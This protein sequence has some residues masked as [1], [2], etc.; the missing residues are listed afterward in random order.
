[1]SS[2]CSSKAAKA[3]FL[4]ICA[5]PTRSQPVSARA[6]LI[7][8]RELQNARGASRVCLC[9]V[10]FAMTLSTHLAF[11]GSPS[12]S[13]SPSPSRRVRPNHDFRH[14]PPHFSC[15][16]L[17]RPRQELVWHQR[18]RDSDR[19]QAEAGT[20][21]QGV[22]AGRQA[23]HGYHGEGGGGKRAKRSHPPCR[24]AFTHPPHLAELA[25]HLE[26]P[27]PARV[28]AP[29]P[30]HHREQRRVGACVCMAHVHVHACSAH[31]TRAHADQEEQEAGGQEGEGACSCSHAVIGVR[32]THCP[33]LSGQEALCGGGSGGGGGESCS[34]A[35]TQSHTQC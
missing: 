13:P 29:D 16:R 12:P 24:Q 11:C 25:L 14:P 23:V 1:M 7:I 30:R 20:Q 31:P 17:F 32:V 26:N 27:G 5:P 33:F 34:H 10:F 19:L 4:P 22:P 15:R 21:V 18:A 28:H 8:I 3:S 9:K 2:M 6:H 35:V